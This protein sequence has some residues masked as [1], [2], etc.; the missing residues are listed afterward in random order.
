MVP[1]PGTV[2]YVTR[3]DQNKYGIQRLFCHICFV[4][5]DDRQMRTEQV[6]TGLE[7]FFKLLQKGEGLL[8]QIHR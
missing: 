3:L 8:W 6:H 7:I 1:K 5:P 4:T 2:P